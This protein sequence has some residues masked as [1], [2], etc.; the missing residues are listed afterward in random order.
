MADASLLL[1]R[2]GEFPRPTDI[3]LRRFRIMKA[4][5][6]HNPS[7]GQ[8]ESEREQLIGALRKAGYTPIY[9]AT[10]V[11]C[12]TAALAEPT[13][14]M[15]VAGGDGTVGKVLTQMPDRRVPVAILPIGSANNIASSFGIGGPLVEIV[16]GLPT[17]ERRK[18]DIGEVFGPWGRCWFVEGVG[19]GAL[20]RV[21]EKIGKH[22]SGPE[23]LEAARRA[24]RKL[25]KKGEPDSVEILLDGQALPARHLMV[26]ILNIAYG[27]PQLLLA[28]E[29]D[30]SDGL[31]DVLLLEPERRDDMRRWLADEDPTDPPPMIHQRGRKVRIT[32]DGTPLHVDDDLPPPEDGRGVVEFELSSEP[33]TILVPS[34]GGRP[35]GAE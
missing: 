35:G 1:V 20:V 2:L 29:V 22:T 26:E 4:T 8:G 27:G 31:L 30:P 23:R 16:A 14:L 6:V 9:Q 33:A 7:A 21:A 13:D 34:G 5:L 24:L 11:G 3:P 28:P 17:A 19:L 15:V 12:L 10:T 25:L 18:L 32:W